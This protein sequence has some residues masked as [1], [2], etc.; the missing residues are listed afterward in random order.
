MQLLEKYEWTKFESTNYFA[1]Q[2]I[3]NINGHGYGCGQNDALLLFSGD[4]LAVHK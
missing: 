3:Q 4:N 2:N 1:E